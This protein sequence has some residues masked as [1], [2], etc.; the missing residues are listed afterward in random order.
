MLRLRTQLVSLLALLWISA[1]SSAERTLAVEELLLR[2]KPAVALVTTRVDADVRLNCGVGP[3]TVEPSAYRETGTAWFVDG[4]G[5]LIT[6]AHVVDPAYRPLPWVDEELKTRAVD[7]ACVD[8]AL[9]KEG[10][11]RGQQPDRE[12]QIRRRVDRTKITVTRRP[13]VTVLLS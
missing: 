9:A 11:T 7:Q 8:P 13:R 12:E 3:I 5:Y 1:L 10:L 2:A 4:R 6:S